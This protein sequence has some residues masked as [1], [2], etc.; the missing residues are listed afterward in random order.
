M[1]GVMK[2][3]WKYFLVLVAACLIPLLTGARRPETDADK[4]VMSDPEVSQAAFL[5]GFPLHKPVIAAVNGFCLGGGCELA[6]H[7]DILHQYIVLAL[8]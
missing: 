1:G 2:L 4:K 3:R 6:M 7:A 5:R 8:G